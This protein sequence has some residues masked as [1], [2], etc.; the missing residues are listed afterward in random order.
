MT[1]SR[2]ASDIDYVDDTPVHEYFE[3][4]YAQYLV[5]P[6]TALQSMPT[7]WQHRFVQCLRELDEAIDWRPMAGDYRVSLRGRDGKRISIT[8]DPLMDYERGRRRIKL[9]EPQ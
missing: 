9:N 1:L 3:L 8:E 5:L 6:R 7:E 4:T 2:L